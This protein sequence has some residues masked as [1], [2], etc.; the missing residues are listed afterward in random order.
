MPNPAKVE[1][2]STLTVIANEIKIIRIYLKHHVNRIVKYKV[3]HCYQLVPLL[4]ILC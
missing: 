3:I 4:Y 2:V 1:A